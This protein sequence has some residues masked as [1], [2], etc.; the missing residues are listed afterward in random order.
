MSRK[1]GKTPFWVATAIL[2]IL[3]HHVMTFL[4]EYT[5]GFAAWL[6]GYK[7]NPFD[8]HYQCNWI[9]LWGIDE[10]VPYREILAAGKNGLT[11]TIAIA[12]MI[13]GFIFFLIGLK[14]LSLPKFQKRWMLFSFVFWFTVNEIGEI[15]SYI[16][17]RTFFGRDD[18]FNFVQATGLS[19]WV[20]FIVGT[21][22]VVWG[23]QRMIRIEELRASTVLRI[24]GKVGRFMFLFIVLMI[25][26]WYYG[27]M[28][29]V[30]V[31]PQIVTY[32]LCW[33]SLALIPLC[34]IFFRKRYM[35]ARNRG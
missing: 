13:D 7:S 16:P 11:A 9:T 26:F 24:E 8:I 4:H 1:V 34:L 2:I 27:G 23:L 19:P 3:S 21:P 6:G 32:P 30:F 28:A 22:F 35:A 10:A 5:H 14:L 33:I 29:F 12:P 17:V 15:Y 20:V 31:Y 18:I 25:C